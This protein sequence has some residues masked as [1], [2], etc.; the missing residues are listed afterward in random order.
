MAGYFNIG[1]TKIRPGAFFNVQGDG[2]AGVPGA[3]DG[4]VAVIFKATMGPLGVVKEFDISESYTKYY[5]TSG[6]TDAIREAVYGGARKIVACRVGTG[7]TCATKELTAATGKVKISAKYPGTASYAVAVRAK[8][9]DSTK[10]EIV[11]YIDNV[12]VEKFSFTAGGDEVSSLIT[13]AAASK[14]FDASK[15]TADAAGVVTNTALTALTGG[16]DPTVATAQY[17]AALE[18]IEKHY[19]NVIIVDT[20]DAAIHALV[21]AFLE[22]I[23]IAGQFGMAVLASD[24]STALETRMQ[25]GANSIPR[26]SCTWSMQRRMLVERNFPVTR[27]LQALPASLQPLLRI[28]LSL[29][30]FSVVIRNLENFSPMPRSKR[31]KRRAALS[32]P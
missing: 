24:P 31:Q 5:G 12:E 23:F 2:Y 11:F 27:L 10:K 19:F 15:G 14:Y 30:E 4:V 1:E 25:T 29:I 8:L 22:R 7:G 28:L 6:T 18:E 32:S 17:S 13:A 9:A 26:R 20:E 16:A 21:A 3:Q